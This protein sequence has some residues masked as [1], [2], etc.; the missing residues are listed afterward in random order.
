ML[1]IWRDNYKVYG[2][3]RLQ[4][5]LRSFGIRIGTSRIIRLMH[6]FNIRSLMCRR[7]KKPETHVDYDQRPNL[8]KNWRI[9]L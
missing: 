2:R 9:K 7:F 4:M 1:N 5:A 6:Q 3:P 8:I